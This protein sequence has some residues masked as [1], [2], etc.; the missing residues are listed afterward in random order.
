MF[1]RDLRFDWD[2][3]WNWRGPDWVDYAN[4]IDDVRKSWQKKNTTI[5]NQN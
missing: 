4:I 1:D 2:A 5:G 3:N